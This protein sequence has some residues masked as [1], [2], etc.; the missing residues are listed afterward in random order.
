MCRFSLR[1]KKETDKYQLWQQHSQ[2]LFCSIHQGEDTLELSFK[3]FKGWNTP[4]SG[5]S[6]LCVFCHVV[7]SGCIS[8]KAWRFDSVLYY[9]M[10]CGTGL[11]KLHQSFNLNESE[12]NRSMLS[13]NY[14]KLNCTWNKSHQQGTTLFL[15]RMPWAVLFVPFLKESATNFAH[16]YMFE[17]FEEE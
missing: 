9:V 2:G 3:W 7:V 5:T 6:L 14:W 1:K 13:S 11:Q 10:V 4:R 16:R 17:A 15:V 8:L 12:F